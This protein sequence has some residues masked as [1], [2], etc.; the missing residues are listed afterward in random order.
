MAA[1]VNRKLGVIIDSGQ[2][3]I[4]IIPVN[5]ASQQGG[6][7]NPVVGLTGF[8]TEQVNSQLGFSGEKIVGKAHADRTCAYDNNA[9]VIAG[10]LC[11]LKGAGIRG[12]TITNS[13]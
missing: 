1:L 6:E 4:D 10:Y 3:Q 2:R 12:F 11:Q 9:D 8:V 5:L 13:A 7:L